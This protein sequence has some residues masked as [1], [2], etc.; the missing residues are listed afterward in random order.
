MPKSSHVR[1]LRT[2]RQF[3]ENH[4]AFPET[5]LRDFVYKSKSRKGKRANG[6][7]RVVVRAGAR[8][9]ID[10][11]KFFLWLDRK[12]PRAS[13]ERRGAAGSAGAALA[14]KGS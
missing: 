14:A 3:A 7:A 11:E 2:I 12:Q 4:Q 9:L 1:T 8:V 10:E 13:R 6:F 5:T